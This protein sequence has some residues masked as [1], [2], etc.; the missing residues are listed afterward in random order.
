MTRRGRGSKR[1]GVGTYDQTGDG[2]HRWRHYVTRATGVRERIAIRKRQLA[3]LDRAVDAFLA[4]ERL[5]GYAPSP[6]RQTL[7]SYCHQWLDTVVSVRNRPSTLAKYCYDLSRILPYIGHHTL[8]SLNAGHIQAA[9]KALAV[10]GYAA[11]TIERSLDVLKNALQTAVDQERITRNVARTVAGPKVEAYHPYILSID[12]AQRLLEAAHGTRLEVLYHV[13]LTLGLRRGE[14]LGL[15][16][17]DVD[18]RRNTIRIAQI[19]TMEGTKVVLSE[20]K[21]ELSRSTLPLPDALVPWLEAQR[22]RVGDMEQ[23]AAVWP[24]HDLVFPAIN[25]RPIRPRN[26]LRE[27]KRLLQRAGLPTTIRLHDLRHACG[28]FLAAQEVHPKVA[29]QILRHTDVQT[30]MKIYTHVTLEQ[31]RTAINMLGQLFNAQEPLEDVG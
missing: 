19:V 16:W 9:V 21:T 24:E 13:A 11:S 20:P 25:G 14:V 4:E 23:I 26:L 10:H 17:S 3:D 30:T 12:E 31:Q 6:D 15:R 1:Y 8:S 18:V 22:Q 5:R 7:A 27:Y 28:S 29:Q 2:R